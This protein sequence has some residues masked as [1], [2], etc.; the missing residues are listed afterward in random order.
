MSKRATNTLST[1]TIN[2]ETAKRLIR[3]VK[4]IMKE[5]LHDCGIYYQHSDH[6]MLKGTALIVGPTDT[7]YEGGF[8]LFD[9]DF[10]ANYPHQPPIVTAMTQGD[11]MRFH[12]N[13]Y[14]SGKVCLSILNTWYGDGWTSCQ[15]ITSILLTIC[16][17][18][19]KDPLLN[20]PG[21]REGSREIKQFNKMVEFENLKISLCK[22]SKL[23]Q[24]MPER[25]HWMQP[26][27]TSRFETDLP[28][29]TKFLKRQLKLKSNNTEIIV[30]VYRLKRVLNYELIDLGGGYPPKPPTVQI[31][32]TA[33]VQI[34]A[35]SDNDMSITAPS[36]V[37]SGVCVID[38][39]LGSVVTSNVN[40]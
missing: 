32:A 28:R 38:G 2:G 36:I 8:Y 26:I 35:S 5:P 30:N 34:G 6:H 29:L 31:G 4:R 20:E 3:D 18:M 17:V 12:P 21:I 1:P 10:P 24:F 33:G 19:T 11:Q 14:T 40:V 39:I 9:L 37:Q 15:S 23:D 25:F 7:P 16:S 27:I 13:M 22:M